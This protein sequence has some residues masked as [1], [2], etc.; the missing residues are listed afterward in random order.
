M[1]DTNSFSLLEEMQTPCL[2]EVMEEG[3]ICFANRAA[4]ERLL[5]GNQEKAKLVGHRFDELAKPFPLPGSSSAWLIGGEVYRLTERRQEGSEPLKQI[6]LTPEPEPVSQDDIGALKR[7]AGVLVHRLRSPLNAVNGFFELIKGDLEHHDTEIEAIEHGLASMAELLD[8][9]HRSGKIEE[10]ARA[11]VDLGK[12]V[13]EVKVGLPANRRRQVSWKIDV[14]EEVTTD[15]VFLA[16]L[17]TELLSNALDAAGDEMEP[18]E[19]SLSEALV[20]QVTNY[21]PQIPKADLQ[22]IFKP[23][24]TT[25]AQNPGLGLTR[26]YLIS[27]VLG[28]RLFLRQNSHVDGVTFEARLAASN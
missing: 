19:V 3:T 14:A 2:L 18:V 22:T 20:V 15:S 5:R 21:G 11:P 24:Y 17:L 26:A 9:I 28:G 1:I 23:F 16:E 7:I 6:I 8:H 13:D 12:I 27:K 25:K 4:R 10:P